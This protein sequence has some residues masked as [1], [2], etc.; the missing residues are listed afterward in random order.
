MSQT[1]MA[2][3]NFNNIKFFKTYAT[4]EQLDEST[5]PEIVFVGKSNVGKS[6]L[7]N[8]LCNNNKLA[9]VSAS[10]GKT[11]TINFFDAT[12]AF[13]VDLPGYGF[14]KRSNSEIKRWT[15]L[16]DEYFSQDRNFAVVISLLDIRH[17]PTQQD[18]ELL[19]FIHENGIPFVIVLTK[20]DKLSKQKQNSQRNSIIKFLQLDSRIPVIVCSAEKNIGIA[21]LKSI[22]QSSI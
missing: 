17:N 16:I 14:A 5:L 13:F 15:K 18:I 3:I 6:S 12:D 21:E 10:P 20:A 22:I 7:L 8:K 19:Q 2:D 4:A 11:I 1:K 9:R